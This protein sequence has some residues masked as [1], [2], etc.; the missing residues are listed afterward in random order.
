M[1]QAKEEQTTSGEVNREVI[2]IRPTTT[3]RE[4]IRLTITQRVA[5]NGEIALATAVLSGKIPSY[6]E[7]PEIMEDVAKALLNGAYFM[8]K[9]NKKINGKR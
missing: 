7:K 1:D 2:T 6:F 4:A 9:F 8:R 3:T 5:D